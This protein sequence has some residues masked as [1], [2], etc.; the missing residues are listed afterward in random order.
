M[1]EFVLKNGQ[2]S[3][4]CIKLYKFV[5]EYIQKNELTYSKEALEVAI[6]LH[7]NSFRDGGEPYIIHPLKITQY[8]MLLNVKNAIYDI[9]KSKLHTAALTGDKTKQDL[10]TLLSVSLLHDVIEDVLKENGYELVT[11]YG[12]SERIYECVKKLSKDKTEVEFSTQNYFDQILSDWITSLV[13]LADRTDNCSSMDIFDYSRRKKYLNEIKDYFY[14]LCSKAKIKYPKFSRIFTIMKYLIVSL[15]ETMASAMNMPEL[16]SETN[17]DKTYNFLKGF[18]IGK[19]NVDNTIMA[20]S[21]AKQ[22]YNGFK[23]K[24]GDDFIVHPLR[25]CSYLVSLKIN[26][27]LICSAAL[28]HE[29]INTCHLPYDGIEIVTEY[30]INPTIWNYIKIIS[31]S[32]NYP[33]KT[34]YEMLKH[35]LP[36]LLV[37]LS[38]RANTC[39]KLIDYSEKEFQE[40]IDE[41]NEFIYPICEYGKIHYPEYEYQIQLMQYHIA[42]VCKMVENLKH[43]K[44]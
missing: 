36:V 7:E 30:D 9:N 11:K 12:F 41:C 21:L 44:N 31:N 16:I 26:D 33:K 20:L 8:L 32:D 38:N 35:S 22:Y 1:Y 6:R 39:T 14:P 25:V 2:P 13:K 5:E 17:P 4:E 18:F 23:R 19:E 27:D 28:L 42:S 37:K 29:I 3:T 34:Y 43:A 24:S 15:T 10:D 40:Y